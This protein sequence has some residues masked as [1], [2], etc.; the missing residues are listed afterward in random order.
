MMLR[1]SGDA[2]AAR[3]GVCDSRL[4]PGGIRGRAMS[5]IHLKS[6]VMSLWAFFSAFVLVLILILFLVLVLRLPCCGVGVGEGGGKVGG[7]SGEV[8]WCAWRRFRAAGMSCRG[9]WSKAVGL[10][11]LAEGPGAA[12]VVMGEREGTRWCRR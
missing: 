8:V 10:V 4:N 7:D 9:R 6:P 11:V 12:G 1:A 2:N 3:P 5:T